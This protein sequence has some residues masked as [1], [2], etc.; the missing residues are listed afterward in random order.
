MSDKR[1]TKQ[2]RGRPTM[3]LD[4]AKKFDGQTE[5]SLARSLI[6]AKGGSTDDT[7]WMMIKKKFPKTELNIVRLVT[8]QRHFCVTKIRTCAWEHVLVIP[9]SQRR[10]GR[11][12]RA[13]AKAKLRTKRLPKR[14]A[15][16]TEKKKKPSRAKARK[17]KR[18]AA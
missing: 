8:W 7:V 1:G 12:T 15:K 14:D 6:L 11:P 18:T 3:S 4:E 5:A 13:P 2:G 16:P 9:G 17:P 10:Q